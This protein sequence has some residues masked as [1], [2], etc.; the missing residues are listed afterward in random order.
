MLAVWSLPVLVPTARY[1]I[2]PVVVPNHEVVC[3]A[4]ARYV[5]ASGWAI[6]WRPVRPTLLELLSALDRAGEHV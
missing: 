2:R 5:G 4:G 3:R 6:V 1:R